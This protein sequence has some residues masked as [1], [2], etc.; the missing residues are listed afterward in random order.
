MTRSTVLPVLMRDEDVI[1]LKEAVFRTGRS[2]K[3]IRR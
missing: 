3:T 2:E 1:T